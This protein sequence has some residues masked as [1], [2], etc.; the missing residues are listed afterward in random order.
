M[1]YSI[2]EKRSLTPEKLVAMLAKK[3][4]KITIEE[5]EKALKILYFLANLIVENKLKT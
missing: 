1:K 4:R 5:A 2:Q 3:G